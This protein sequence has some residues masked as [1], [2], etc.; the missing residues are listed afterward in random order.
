MKKSSEIGML[1]SIFLN[2]RDNMK[3]YHWQTT[4][5]ARHKASCSLIESLD[6]KTDKFIEVI[7]G[8]RKE[9]LVLS[10]KCEKFILNNQTDDSAF[11]L[12]INF[13]RWLEDVLPQY[14]YENETELLNIR[15]EMLADVDQTIYLF[16]FK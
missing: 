15:D 2:V 8:C 16:T 14:I 1:A 13:K 10:Q 9:R 7:Q 4:L 5:Y 6:E 11:E 3:I 12:L